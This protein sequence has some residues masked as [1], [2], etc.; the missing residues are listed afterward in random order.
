[1]RLQTRLNI[2][3]QFCGI[4]LATVQRSAYVGRG[5]ARGTGLSIIYLIPNNGG[6]ARE[7]TKN[8]LKGGWARLN[9]LAL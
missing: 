9:T 6:M 5:G 2:T 1:M 3:G 8:E 7:G 4:F